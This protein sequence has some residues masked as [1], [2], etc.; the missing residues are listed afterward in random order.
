[1]GFF[2]TKIWWDFQDI[3]P[4]DVTGACLWLDWDGFPISILEPRSGLKL[5]IVVWDT[6][7]QPL[8]LLNDG[9]SNVAKV[10]NRGKG[11]VLK[12]DWIIVSCCLQ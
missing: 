4:T 5:F 11:N 2:C 10:R 9:N 3:L 6:K 1:M 12:L 7:C 8:N